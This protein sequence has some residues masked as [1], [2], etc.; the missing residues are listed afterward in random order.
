[1]TMKPILTRLTALLLAPLAVCVSL[2]AAETSTLL[3]EAAFPRILIHNFLVELDEPAI[4]ALA[5]RDVIVM[6]AWYRNDLEVIRKIRRLNPQI[7]ILMYA[8][9]DSAYYTD[10]QKHFDGR[11]WGIGNKDEAR[12]FSGHPEAWL[13]EC[14]SGR[15][16]ADL[17]LQQREA[18]VQGLDA[19]RLRESFGANRRKPKAVSPKVVLAI[20]DEL[21]R[22][23]AMDGDRLTLRR[24]QC[25]TKPA[26]HRAGTTVR[27]VNQCSWAN[28]TQRGGPSDAEL[29][30]INLSDRAPRVGGRR[31]WQIK[32][33]F[34]IK[35][36][37]QDPVWRA[38]FDGFFFD[39]GHEWQT[40]EA[41]A[42]DLDNDGRPD[43]NV[44]ASLERG[45]RSFFDYLRRQCGSELVMTPNN[46]SDLL[47]AVNGRHREYFTGKVHV[48]QFTPNDSGQWQFSV[49]EYSM[50]PYRAYQAAG[51]PPALSINS[52]QPGTWNDHRAVRFGLGSTLLMDGCFQ[53]RQLSGDHGNWQYWYDEYSVDASGAATDGRAGRHWLGKPLGEARQIAEP[54]NSPNL[55]ATAQWQLATKRGSTARFSSNDGVLRLETASLPDHRDENVELTTHIS[56]DLR[57]GDTA[58]LSL[59]LRASVPRL[60]RFALAGGN[61]PPIRSKV[62]APLFATTTWTRRIFSLTFRDD[63]PMKGY[64]LSF[65][66]G[67]DLGTVEL[68]NVSWQ[69]GSAVLGWQREFEHGLVVVNPTLRP[70]EFAITGSFKRIRGKQDAVHNNG[71]PVD[72][73][74]TVPPCDAYL[75]IRTP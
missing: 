31:P 46:I 27:I 64:P 49:W 54:L 44:F 28:S 30:R 16:A 12:Q 7:V 22:V 74:I 35:T 3:P 17:S 65:S 20:G 56:A 55:L 70:Q 26:P 5:K 66:A 29:L 11:T 73:T 58:T 10:T 13:Y 67:D 59:D 18:V 51:A 2:Q 41:L 1:M 52:T 69:M 53:F 8:T 45:V 9:L 15:L 34:Y 43:E 6:A 38:C 72:R 39:N 57:A 19:E 25:D 50:E 36:Y 61:V 32:A 48:P 62:V 24:G 71:Q 4:E 21:A 60:I 40:L 14:P 63:R 75:L 47:P 42:V 68:R 37:W 33:D 23:E